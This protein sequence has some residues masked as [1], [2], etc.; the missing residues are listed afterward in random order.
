MKCTLS[1]AATNRVA[2]LRGRDTCR[3]GTVSRTAP[4]NNTQCARRRRPLLAV[5]HNS[6][7]VSSSGRRQAAMRCVQ[8]S[9][10]IRLRAF[11][12]LLFHFSFALLFPF[13]KTNYRRAH[14]NLHARSFSREAS[15]TKSGCDSSPPGRHTTRHTHTVH[16]PPTHLVA[17][18]MLC[19][20]IAIHK[21]SVASATT[22]T[23]QRQ[24]HATRATPYTSDSREARA[25]ITDTSISHLRR[26]Q[27]RCLRAAGSSALEDRKR[28][29]Y[30]T[31]ALRLCYR[32]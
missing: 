23:R 21:Q 15:A 5:A 10:A 25:A 2:A 29:R 12:S 3:R 28:R 31:A 17:L 27:T 19:A 18:Q 9:L 13:W 22:A 32:M 7:I 1:P 26:G 6:R 20:P 4:R 30:V 24:Q 14:V 16:S 11:A 8:H